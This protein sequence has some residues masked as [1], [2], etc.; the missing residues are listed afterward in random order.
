MN[1]MLASIDGRSKRTFAYPCGDMKIGDTFYLDGMKKDF[2]AARGVR[3]DMPTPDKVD[4]Y[5]VSCYGINGQSGD[6]LISMVRQ[7][8]QKQGL[9]VFLFHGVGGEHSLNVSLEAHRQLLQFLAAN[10]N[11]IWIATMIDVTEFIKAQGTRH[12]ED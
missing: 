12:K 7:A 11:E 5:N 4:L 8:M 10:K 1:T 9:L 3:G 6:Q 2:I